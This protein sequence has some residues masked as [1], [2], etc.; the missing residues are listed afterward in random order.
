MI[1]GTLETVIDIAVNVGLAQRT[2]CVP[3]AAVH[4][5]LD[6]NG[7]EGDEF[8]D[9]LCAEFGSWVAEWPWSR[10]VDFNEPPASLGPKIWKLLRLPNPSVAF[11]G[12]VEERL[13]LR[14]IA[15]VIEKGQ[16]FEP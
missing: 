4:P 9:A 7:D 2:K 5:D 15:A 13:E 1:L 10:F 8:V 3:N 12:Y 6:I 11:P 16:W 14:H